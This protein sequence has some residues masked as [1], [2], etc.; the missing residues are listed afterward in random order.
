MKLQFLGTGAAEGVPSVFCDCPTCQEVRKRGEK[1]FHTRAQVLVDDVLSVDFPPDAYYHSLKFGVNLRG[2]KSA[3]ITHSHMDHFYAHDFVLRGYKYARGGMEKIVIY[4]NEEVKKVFDECVRR[5]MR[6]DVAPLVEV[7]VIK[8]FEE[9]ETE[10]Y[11][12][13]PLLAQHSQKE[14]ALLFLIQKDGKKYLHLADTGRLPNRSYEKLA[15]YL[16]GEKRK[17]DCI[18]FDCTFLYSTGGETSRHM[19]LEDNKVVFARLKELGLV[20]EKTQRVITHYSHN[21]DPLE[22]TLLQAEED[23]NVVAARDGLELNV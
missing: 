12:V 11:K 18:V 16:K 13:F 5:E 20:D 14:D 1:A 6:P 21:N 3:L 15:E 9:F 4:G 2:I 19:G 22:E 7:K 8:P 23:Y 10:G 17:I